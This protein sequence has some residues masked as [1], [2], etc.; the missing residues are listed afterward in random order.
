MNDRQAIARRIGHLGELGLDARSIADEHNGQG[1]VLM[2]G[3]DRPRDD[4]SRGV[5]APHGV[6]GYPHGGLR[7]EGVSLGWVRDWAE[8]GL[9][10]ETTTRRTTAGP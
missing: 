5:V 3:F 8:R 6:Q 9:D 7:A 2:D 10:L 1:R 4:R